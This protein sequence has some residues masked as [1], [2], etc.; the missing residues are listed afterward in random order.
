MAN[1]VRISPAGGSNHTISFTCQPDPTSPTSKILYTLIRNPD[2]SEIGTGEISLEGGNCDLNDVTFHNGDKNDFSHV[3]TGF[4][5][6]IWT[7][8]ITV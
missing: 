6:K 3:N 2:D 4:G 8:G 7:K 5:G 1:G